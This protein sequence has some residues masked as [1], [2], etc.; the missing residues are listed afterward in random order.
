M[1]KQGIEFRIKTIKAG[2]KTTGFQ[3][4]AV[5][6]SDETLQ[7]Q[8]MRFYSIVTEPT[9]VFHATDCTINGKPSKDSALEYALAFVRTAM[10]ENDIFVGV[11]K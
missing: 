1:N 4:F 6:Y 10:G 5:S 11:V 2:R 9:A 7:G 8:P 3:V